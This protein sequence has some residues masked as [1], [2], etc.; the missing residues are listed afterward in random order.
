MYHATPSPIV[1]RTKIES[2]M[3]RPLLSFEA[4]ELPLSQPEASVL[5]S[6][7]HKHCNLS[8]ISSHVDQSEYSTVIP[9]S[10]GFAGD[11]SLTEVQA[12]SAGVECY[13]SDSPDKLHERRSDSAGD[14]SRSGF[15]DNPTTRSKCSDV[16]DIGL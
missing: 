2:E 15:T 13:N 9:S 5:E 4:I 3:T 14:S 11:T 12:I 8:L 6:T 1:R 10:T 16:E 7:K